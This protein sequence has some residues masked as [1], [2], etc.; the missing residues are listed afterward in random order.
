[1]V[2]D[3]NINIEG[4]TLHLAEAPGGFIEATRYIKN[5]S[6]ITSDVFSYR[7]GFCPNV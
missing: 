7:R 3:H 1:M 4:N 2:V 5:K 6:G